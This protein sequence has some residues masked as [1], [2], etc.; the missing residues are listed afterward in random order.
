ME[1]F[2]DS[3]SQ[4]SLAYGW[5]EI[6]AVFTAV[7]YVFLAAKTNRWCFFFGL[8]SSAIYIYLATSL[9]FYFDSAINIYYVF[10]SFYG[11][12]SW[13]NTSTGKLQGILKMPKKQFI[14]ILSAGLLLT[15]IL[16]SIVDHFSDASLP[17]IDAF[18][19]VFAIIA[20]WMV[21][22]KYLENWL[23]WIVVD[24]IAAAMY[25][26]KNLFITA[27]LF[28]LYAIISIVGYKKW[29]IQLV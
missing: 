18:T 27:A 5:L 11:W 6:I 17:Y 19:T 8:I 25:F 3:I 29:K 13:S 12:F 4:E 26:H 22:K 24:L 15:A 28:L 23:I 9:K 14:I 20:T 7:I 10:M 16:A 2:F 21:V 1:S